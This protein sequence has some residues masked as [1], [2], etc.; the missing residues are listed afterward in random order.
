MR[1]PQSPHCA[2]EIYLRN[3]FNRLASP[4]LD[5]GPQRRVKNGSPKIGPPGRPF[6]GPKTRT[7]REA[8]NQAPEIGSRW[9][10]QIRYPIS[11]P[12]GR[13]IWRPDSSP[14]IQD[15]VAG[16]SQNGQQLFQNWCGKT[17]KAAQKNCKNGSKKVQK[18]RG[19]N[20]RIVDIPIGI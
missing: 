17:S 13:S 6:S 3:F 14:R 1:I 19:P 4:V 12:P 10:H 16:T 2:P 5:L 11:D 9:V 7:S 15:T 20:S 18:W 8:S